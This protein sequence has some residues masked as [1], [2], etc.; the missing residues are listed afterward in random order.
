[1]LSTKLLTQKSNFR[2]SNFKINQKG[3]FARGALFLWLWDNQK[4][5]N[6]QYN[7]FFSNLKTRLFMKTKCTKFIFLLLLCLV[8]IPNYSKASIEENPEAVK[9][10]SQCLKATNATMYGTK[11]CG[12]C[13]AQKEMFGSYFKNVRF[14]DCRASS[15]ASEECREQ[16]VGKFPQWN[17]QNGKTIV[18]E[19]DLDTILETSGC[20][21]YVAQALSGTPNAASLETA[22]EKPSS[23]SNTTK[24]SS[25]KKASST[26]T[27]SYGSPEQLAQCLK[28]KGVKFYGSPKCGHCNKQK[29]MFEG[30]FEKYLST[31]FHNCKG[32]SAEQA[33]CARRGT[34]PFPTWV[35][36]TSGKKLPGPEHSLEQIARTFSCTATDDST[37]T[38]EVDSEAA[39]QKAVNKKPQN[40]SL[41][42]Y[43]PK[44]QPAE[45]EAD[46]KSSLPAAVDA[47]V[48]ASAPS[49]AYEANEI[50]Q[51]Q[52]KLASCLTDRKITLYGITDQNKGK[53]AQ[54]KA[55][56][57]QLSELGNASSKI[58]VVDCSAGQAE[59]N[60]ILVYPT[61]ILDNKNE[62]AGVY[63]LTNLAQILQCPI[64]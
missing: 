45:P 50:V 18:R 36:P 44:V 54:Y 49:N 19:A 21:A 25:T 24:T 33:E 41:D 35:E 22:S 7:L 63:E 11:N 12:H 59:C 2:Q 31:N 3:C 20:R 64:D 8:Q 14:V 6:K 52:T 28:A 4:S 30:A 5:K 32:S 48:L 53:A 61:W 43:T 27:G 34:Y 46:R 39:S 40:D 1:L 55:T 26:T 10:L 58:K 38:N 56:K 16:R 13:N 60:G 15:K 47:P 37:L 57:D 23:V 51:K 29:E 62:L 17:F 42:S 9:A